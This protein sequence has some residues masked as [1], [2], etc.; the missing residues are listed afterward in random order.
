MQHLLV[1]TTIPAVASKTAD[2]IIVT[3]KYIYHVVLRPHV[4]A[5]SGLEAKALPQTLQ[6]SSWVT[7][8]ILLLFFAFTY[9]MVRGDKM[10]RSK[11]NDFMY[12]KERSSI[13][14]ES[15]VN[16]SRFNL[17]FSIIFIVS[18]TFFLYALA[19]PNDYFICDTNRLFGI[20]IFTIF[21]L[22]YLLLKFLI[23]R[24]IGSIFISQNVL[25]VF[26][27]GYFSV[28]FTVGLFLFPV[29]VGLIYGTPEQ[30]EVFLYIGKF[31]LLVGLLLIL[32][33]IVQIF[34][35]GIYSIFY[36]LLYLCILEI[37]PVLLLVRAIN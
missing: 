1:N 35:T 36:I 21:A 32:Y 18:A 4:E 17:L 28:V 11:V 12:S 24:F 8:L 25:S 22:M 10:L 26:I 33:K 7:A 20:H 23:I 37:L 3:T 2:S 5:V 30:S 14:L 15:S 16:E 27:K 29:A 34:L 6:D 13:F 19:N 9:I 31:V